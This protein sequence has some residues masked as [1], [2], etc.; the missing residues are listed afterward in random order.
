LFAQGADAAEQ[1]QQIAILQSDRSLAEKDAAC[2]RLK[3]IG[4]AHCV[5]ALAALL[6]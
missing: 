1:D 4:T 5:P 3:W 2:A 6:T